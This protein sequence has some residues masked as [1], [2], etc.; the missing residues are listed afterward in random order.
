MRK[1]TYN[2]FA[3]ILPDTIQKNYAADNSVNDLIFYIDNKNAIK[4]Y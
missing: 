3:K 2:L 4:N 1:K